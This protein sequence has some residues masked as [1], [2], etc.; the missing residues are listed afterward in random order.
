MS[1]QRCGPLV[2]ARVR[3]NHWLGSD[4]DDSAS[5]RGNWC[6]VFAHPLKVEMNGLTNCLLRSGRRVARSYAARQIWKIGGK[7]APA[8]SMTIA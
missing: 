6:A 8:F 4:L 1:G 7:V 2:R 5:P 3:S